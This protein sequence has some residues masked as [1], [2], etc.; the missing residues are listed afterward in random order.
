[1]PH[2]TTIIKHMENNMFSYLPCQAYKMNRTQLQSIGLCLL[3]KNSIKHWNTCIF[4]IPPHHQAA[5][6]SEQSSANSR[7]KP[8]PAQ[9]AQRSKGGAGGR[10]PKALK[11]VYVYVHVHVYEYVYVYV[12][13]YIYIYIY[14]Y[15]CIDRDI[16]INRYAEIQINK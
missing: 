3:S 1:M 14:M 15:V 12:H 11:Y 8:I 2:P 7:Q 6:T 9:I 4:T 10:R 16:D 5:L 13:I